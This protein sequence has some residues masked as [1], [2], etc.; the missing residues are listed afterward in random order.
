MYQQIVT[1]VGRMRLCTRVRY[2]RDPVIYFE[3]DSNF[4][5]SFPYIVH[6]CDTIEAIRNCFTAVNTP[7]SAREKKLE[8]ET[9]KKFSELFTTA[10]K[11]LAELYF[12]WFY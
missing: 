12:F 3:F 4:T 5:N 10:A 9:F 11:D 8:A 7:I 6:S 2:V 1:A